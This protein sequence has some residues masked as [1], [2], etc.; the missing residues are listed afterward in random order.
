MPD[1]PL[2]KARPR[3]V[4]VLMAARRILKIRK[5]VHL[6]NEWASA[7]RNGRPAD[8]PGRGWRVPDDPDPRDGAPSRRNDF[9]GGRLWSL[10]QATPWSGVRSSGIR[11]I[12]EWFAA[13]DLPA[14]VLD[15]AFETAAMTHA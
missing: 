13:E 1:V 3:R 9:E 5:H 6:Y 11:D 8:P 4:T 14:D 12:V 15:E 7:I 2:R 10:L